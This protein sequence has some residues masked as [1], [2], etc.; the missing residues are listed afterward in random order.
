MNIKNI[1][2]LSMCVLQFT[3]IYSVNNHLS[4]ENKDKKEYAQSD[5]LQACDIIEESS[6]SKDDIIINSLKDIKHLPL[7][8]QFKLF[9]IY[10][11]YLRFRGKCLTGTEQ[12]VKDM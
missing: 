10:R 3:A 6:E 4:H 5:I 2:V 1:I 8:T 7:D 11:E 9:N 12:I